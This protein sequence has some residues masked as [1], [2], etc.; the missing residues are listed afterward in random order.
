MHI[1]ICNLCNI[2]NYIYGFSHIGI[3]VY[4][5]EYPHDGHQRAPL[6]RYKLIVFHQST[7]QSN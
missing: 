7:F 4:Q 5:S 6:Y 2:Y 1:H 3:H